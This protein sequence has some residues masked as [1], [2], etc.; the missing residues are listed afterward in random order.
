[1]TQLRAVVGSGSFQHNDRFSVLRRGHSVHLPEQA[2]EGLDIRNSDPFADF[3][4]GHLRVCQQQ[5][6]RFIDAV[7]VEIIQEGL[8]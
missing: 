8:P 6:A 7:G 5:V 2:V 1:M 4:D 3:G